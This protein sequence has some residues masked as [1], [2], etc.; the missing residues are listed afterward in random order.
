M[1][2][3]EMHAQA[4]RL[5]NRLERRV[6]ELEK[7][8]QA[9]ATSLE[10]ISLIAGR[11]SYGE[12]PIPTY[13]EDFS[14]V[15]GFAANRAKVAREA[16]GTAGVGVRDEAQRRL[17]R[18]FNESPRYS[19]EGAL[20]T[21]DAALQAADAVDTLTENGWIWDGDQWQ[22]PPAAGVGVPE[23]PSNRGLLQ[24]AK[25]AVAA[26]KKWRMATHGPV[27]NAGL[28]YEAAS[29]LESAIQREDAAGVKGLEQ[30]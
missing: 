8:L 13:M 20:A 23:V 11:K 24:A 6:A 14:Q 22:R 15:R 27:P 28:I 4:A 25:Q 7:A 16:L 5:A 1:A 26:I 10:T 2:F 12:P 18:H 21:A 29:Y 17:A 19:V 30:C 9:A 3:D